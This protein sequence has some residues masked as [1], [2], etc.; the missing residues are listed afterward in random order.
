[1][2]VRSAKKSVNGHRLE[3]L[4]GLGFDDDAGTSKRGRQA[5][6]LTIKSIEVFGVAMPLVGDFTSGGV[7]KSTIKCVVARV[8][9]SDGTIGVSSIDPSTRATSPNTGPE[10][11][12]AMRDKVAPMLLG[13]DASNLHHIHRLC[14]S[15]CPNQPGVAAGMELACADLVG[16][17]L[18]IALHQYLGGAVQSELKFNGWIGQLDPDSAAAEAK[19]W[20]AAG[21]AS[22]KIKV[23]SGIDADHDRVAAVRDAVGSGMQ[24]RID[25]NEQYAPEDAISLS[26]ALKPYDLQLFEQPAAQDDY[27]GLAEVRKRGAIPVMADETIRDHASLL[28][29]I[30][31]DAADYVKFGIKQV[32]GLTNAAHLLATAEAAGLPVVLGHGFGLD[33]STMAEI[34]LASTSENVVSGLEC[35]G[36]LKVKDSVATTPLDLSSGAM[37]LPVAA[38][39]GLSLDDQKLAEYAF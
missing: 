3:V 4:S 12:V 11:A 5:V 22:A 27:E 18:G 17:R 14:V 36:P 28:R 37:T 25:A 16:Q 2:L 35:V 32:G 30:K 19:R 10:L 9:A 20:L 38:G 15:C 13:E 39:I 31:A 7:S 34:M 26:L 29:T 23:G 21:F 24:L 1:M 8:T 6:Q 33:L